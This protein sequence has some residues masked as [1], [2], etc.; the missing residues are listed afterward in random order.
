MQHPRVILVSRPLRPDR[1]DGTVQ[2]VR[3]VAQGFAMERARGADPVDATVFVP[4]GVSPPAEGIQVKRSALAPARSDVLWPAATLAQ[5]VLAPSQAIRHYFFTPTRPVVRV[6]RALHRARPAPSVQTLCSAPPPEADLAELIFADHVVALSSHTR[7]RLLDAGLAPHRVS[8]IPPA[9]SP[10]PP[11]PGRRAR[12]RAQLGIPAAATLIVY[13]GDWDSAG[14]ALAVARTLPLLVGRQGR[15]AV[16]ACRPKGAGHQ[17]IAA[18]VRQILSAS[19]APPHRIHLR[20]TLPDASGLTA[21][22]LAAG[23]DVALFPAERLPNKM[24]LPLVLLESLAAGVPAV[25]SD[26]GPLAD[27][28]AAGAAV[29]APPE[30]PELLAEAVDGLLQRRETYRA[31]ARA[32]RAWCEEVG[33][34]RHL[35]EAHR[36]LYAP[37]GGPTPTAP[38]SRD[39]PGGGPRGHDRP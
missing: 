4:W 2:L 23:A 9:V 31:V 24:D 15:H 27:L 21:R 35:A 10:P 36:R 14:A 34:L 7:A 3:A 28:V 8:V 32:A 30:D 19:G 38:G 20:G 39:S 11:D 13:L 22:D 1:A 25:V 12:V 16:L 26:R 17:Q 33:D 37:L 18:E 5:L 6:L 29:G